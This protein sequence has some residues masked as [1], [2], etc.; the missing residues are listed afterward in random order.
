LEGP[1]MGKQIFNQ[2]SHCALSA[3]EKHAIHEC[4]GHV[5]RHVLGWMMTH[6]KRNARKLLHRS[7]AHVGLDACN[8]G[9]P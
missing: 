5:D 3:H 9:Q 4:G 6:S 7:D 8:A 1:L 2:S